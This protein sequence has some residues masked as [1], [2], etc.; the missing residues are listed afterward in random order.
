MLHCCRKAVFARL[1]TRLRAL[2]P[3]DSPL[4][5]G[6]YL[7]AQWALPLQSDVLAEAFQ[8]RVAE[9]K[10]RG[11][12]APVYIVK[13]DGGS[14][15]DG[16]TLTADPCKHSWNSA[17]ER[18]VQEYIGQP[19]LIDGLKFD[20]RLYVLITSARPLRAYLY[21]EGLARFAVEGYR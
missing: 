12:P 13:P 8:A 5:D 6:K 1:V 9:A 19:L 14:M 7:P 16:I 21:R 10:R 20:L 11:R 15:G 17:T 2:L 3:P 18:V 4:H